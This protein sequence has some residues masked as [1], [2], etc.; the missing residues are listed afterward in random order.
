MA[1]DDKPS[2]AQIS[3]LYHMIQW[4]MPT[5]EAQDAVRWLEKNATKKQ[6]SEELGRVRKLN[7]ERSLTRDECF[8]S[9]VWKEYYG[10]INE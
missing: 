3:A 1:W 4:K 9:D 10:L 2:K 5:A 7:I 8:K 6:V